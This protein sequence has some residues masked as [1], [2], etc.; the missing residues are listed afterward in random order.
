M[1]MKKVFFLTAAICIFSQLKANTFMQNDTTGNNQ[2]TKKEQADGWQLLFDGNT[3]NGWR[4]F[5]NEKGSWKVSDGMLCSLSADEGNADLIT[6]AVYTD[7]EL[8]ID[9]KIS[10]EGN[11]GIL[12]L[13]TENY[14]HTYLSGPEYQLIDD[15]GFPE[16][17]EDWQKTGANYAMHAPSVMAAHKPGEWNTTKILVNKGYVEHWLNG[18]KVV[19]YTLWNDEWKQKKAAGKWKDAVGY[20]ALKTGHIALQSSHSKVETSGICFRN[21]KIKML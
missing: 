17:I 13:V 19:E 21:I 9:W 14:D 7:F 3:M 4:T 1:F 11:S 20:A 8:E 2:L 18:K 16:K 10:A 12:Y 6:D 15:D 5:K